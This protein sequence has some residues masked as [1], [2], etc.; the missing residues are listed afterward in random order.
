M[1]GPLS[2]HVTAGRC[3]PAGRRRPPRV[4]SGG[5]S[6]IL[7]RLARGL[8]LV[9]PGLGHQQV[10]HPLQRGARL[11]GVR[12]LGAD[13]HRRLQ[14]ALVDADRLG[15][16]APGSSC[17]ARSGRSPPPRRRA[18][19]ARAS[20]SSWSHRFSYSRADL[21]CRA[22]VAHSPCAEPDAAQVV[23]LRREQQL[24][25][26]VEILGE[27]LHPLGRRRAPPPGSAA[28]RSPPDGTGPGRGSSR[29]PRRG[30]STA[31]KRDEDLAQGPLRALEIAPLLLAHPAL[32]QRLQL[33]GQGRSRAL[34]EL[35]ED[36]RR[37][38]PSAP[39]CRAWW[40]SGSWP[41]ARRRFRA[42]DRPAR[43]SGARPAPSPPGARRPARR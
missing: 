3:V 19:G 36:R 29:R 30:S 21:R 26:V 4:R 43:S 33:A 34:G 6:G 40:P 14:R 20:R 9:A 27:L 5:R 32:H 13:A 1:N 23:A 18:P 2:A 8:L 25:L 37:P 16:S 22:A 31:S 28:G 17:A 7:G 42:P 10:L 24:G 38:R 41:P 35:V 11:L 39:A 12:V 15:R